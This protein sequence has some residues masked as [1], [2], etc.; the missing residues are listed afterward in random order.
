MENT[1]QKN[2]IKIVVAD[3]IPE[4]LN[5]VC[6]LIQEV[7]PQAEIVGKHTTLKSVKK[8]IDTLHPDVV[9]LDIQFSAEGKTAF[10][11]LEEYQRNQKNNFKLI[12]FSGHCEPEYYD[13]AFR[14]NAVHFLPKPIDKDR[15]N[16][17]LKRTVKDQ[18]SKK[19]IDA[20]DYRKNKLIVH[21]AT[22]SY[23]ITLDDIVYLQSKEN[24][25][26][27]LLSSE[28]V[29]ISSRNLGYFET[30]L[31]ENKNFARIHSNTIMNIDYI[32]GIDNRTERNII[33]RP[34]FGK[35]KG[36]REKFKELFGK[37][38]L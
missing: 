6:S 25:T 22:K 28:E 19:D 38:E 24:R 5:M 18:H 27:I 11:L 2:K 35:V 3:D 20:K 9:I 36:S 32:Q 8:S 17:A 16:D 31:F 26:H 14:Y 13:M 7:C 23:F 10:D 1:E 21:T 4:T 33:L 29:I 34:P 12:I 30:Q 15:L 37:L